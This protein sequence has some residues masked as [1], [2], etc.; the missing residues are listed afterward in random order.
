M[1]A[2]YGVDC[3]YGYLPQ[4]PVSGQTYD[5]DI[6]KFS[7]TTQQSEVCK[8][9]KAC[10][11]LLDFAKTNWKSSKTSIDIGCNIVE[12]NKMSR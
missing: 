2:G 12:V 10:N 6:A 9:F 1:P 11:E 3:Q 5:H 4:E 8:N 7:E